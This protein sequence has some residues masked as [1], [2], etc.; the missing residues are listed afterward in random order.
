M[1]N[2][3]E[4]YNARRYYLPKCVFK[5]YNVIINGENSYDQRIDFDIKH[6]EEIRKLTTGKDYTTDAGNLCYRCK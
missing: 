2:N 3:T 1:D 6:Y 5:I 4:R